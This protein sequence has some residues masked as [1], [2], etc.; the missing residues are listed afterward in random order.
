MDVLVTSVDD[1]KVHFK[2]ATDA[3]LSVIVARLARK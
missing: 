2:E 3:Q 1:M